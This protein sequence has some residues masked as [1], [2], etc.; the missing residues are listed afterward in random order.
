ML[1]DFRAQ[2]GRVHLKMHREYEDQEAHKV[3][4]DDYIQKKAS[5]IKQPVNDTTATLEKEITLSKKA[6]DIKVNELHD[7]NGGFNLMHK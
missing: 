2:G 3:Y 1:N 4:G 7:F 6:S 5:Q